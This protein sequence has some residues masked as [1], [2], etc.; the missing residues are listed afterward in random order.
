MPTPPFTPFDLK[1]N[2]DVDPFSGVGSSSAV[3][4]A[5]REKAAVAAGY[6]VDGGPDAKSRLGRFPV[7]TPLSNFAPRQPSA[8]DQLRDTITKD[9]GRY[10]EGTV[11]PFQGAVNR[12]SAGVDDVGNQIGEAAQRSVDILGG[13][14]ADLSARGDKAAGDIRSSVSFLDDTLA[15]S[16]QDLDDGL[17]KGNELFDKASG[18]ADSSVTSALAAVAGYNASRD[19]TIQAT[20]AGLERRVSTALKMIE[21]GRDPQTGNPL[22]LGEQMEARAR[23]ESDLSVTL[24]ERITTFRDESSQFLAKLQMSASQAQ[25]SAGQLDADIATRAGSLGVQTAETR[26][27]V[28]TAV[29]STKADAFAKAEQVRAHYQ[30][31]SANLANAMSGIINS[32]SLNAV[33][34]SLQ[35]RQALAQMIRESPFMSITEGLAA[36]LSFA[37]APGGR[38]ARGV[39]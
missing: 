24:A 7:R 25:L 17:A 23:L 19:A 22:S 13:A 9:Y 36:M 18:Y 12:M 11:T 2:T 37:T 33:S 38:S 5:D 39:V 20:T 16:N 14:R 1:D 27:R 21:A 32:A 35:G 10:Q 28:G 30:E 8:L 26:A 15:R 4:Q 34:L 29:A 6:A 3:S 31:L